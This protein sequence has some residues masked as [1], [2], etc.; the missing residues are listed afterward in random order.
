LKSKTFNVLPITHSEAKPW[1]V[2]KHYAKRM[3]QIQFSF[4]LYVDGKLSGVCCFGQPAC[5]ANSKLGNYPM[6]ELVRLVVDTELQNACSILVSKSLK[7]LPKPIAVVS[8]SDQNAGHVGYVY[9][10]TNWI[11]TGVSKGDVEYII[12][13]KK[14]HRKNAYN[15]FG[16]GSLF[17][18]KEMG[19]QV[20]VLKQGDKH[21]YYFLLGSKKEKKRN[22]GK[23]KLQTKTLPKRRI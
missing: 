20:E 22:D 3:C 17:K 15:Q 19:H 9:Q 12:D 13:G 18:I 21:R 2:K 8:Y 6:I 10:A 4:G 11:Y 1:I 7:L 16:T 14:T 23:F 5:Q